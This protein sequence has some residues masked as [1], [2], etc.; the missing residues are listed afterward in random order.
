MPPSP[1]AT[2]RRRLHPRGGSA[3]R[4]GAAP[5]PAGSAPR[6][7]S[8][9]G[10]SAPPPPGGS[11]RGSSSL[12]A[13]PQDLR[14]APMRGTP[15]VYLTSNRGLHTLT[16]RRLR[17]RGQG[18]GAPLQMLKHK[19]T[20]Q[21][22]DQGRMRDQ[23]VSRRDWVVT[24]SDDNSRRPVPR[25]PVPRRVSGRPPS[26]AAL[27]PAIEGRGCLPGIAAGPPGP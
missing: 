13:P 21:T 2:A 22:P 12:G 14:A 16:P 18:G 6:R 5:P 8:S 23:S 27:L 3:P 11:R 1:G 24:S 10:R 9:S 7:G 25:P 15:L 4:R 20:K 26:L 17:R 19:T